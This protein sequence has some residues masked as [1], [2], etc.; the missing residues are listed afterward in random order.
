MQ[1]QPPPPPV[2]IPKTAA[3]SNQQAGKSLQELM[4]EKQLKQT[5]GPQVRGLGL[6]VVNVLLVTKF[7]GC[8]N[9]LSEVCSGMNVNSQEKG[10]EIGVDHLQ[11]S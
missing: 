2:L 9:W 1:P 7:W 11:R 10:N 6:K 5:E 4:R 8:Y 3:P